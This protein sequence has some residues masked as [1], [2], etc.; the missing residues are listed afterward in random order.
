MADNP[1]KVKN[2]GAQVVKGSPSKGSGGKTT[3]AK[4]GDLRS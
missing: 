1:Y 2:Q 4:G 3:V